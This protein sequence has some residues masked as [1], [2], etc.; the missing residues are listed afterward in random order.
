MTEIPR[1]LDRG[2]EHTRIGTAALQGRHR[3]ASC[4]ASYNTDEPCEVLYS[5][6]SSHTKPYPSFMPCVIY[7]PSQSNIAGLIHAPQCYTRARLCEYMCVVVSGLALGWRNEVPDP[8]RNSNSDLYFVGSSLLGC[9]SRL[10][11]KM[12]VASGL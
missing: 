12:D 11:D 4:I 9:G 8:F 7:H 3:I 1:I 6:V 5:I 10:H 2:M